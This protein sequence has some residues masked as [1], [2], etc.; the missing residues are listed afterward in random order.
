MPAF[1]APLLAGVAALQTPAAPLVL[2]A[3]IAL[4]GV[5][6]RI[7]HLALDEAH[8]R[9]FVA[10][11]GNGTLEVVDLAAKQVWKRVEGLREPQG[12]VYLPARGEVWV[13]QGAGGVL[14]VY[15]GET[16]ELLERIKLGPDGDNLSF[17]PDAQQVWLG[18]ASGALACID[19]AGRK[20]LGRARLPGHPEA[21]ALEPKGKRVFANVPSERGVCVVDREKQEQ[22]AFWPIES[23]QANYPLLLVEGEKQLF[24]GCRNPGRLVALD[25][26]SGK[27]VV[28]LEL[29]GDADD[30][31]YDQARGRIY[32]SCGEGTIDV[33]ARQ[34]PA[35]TWK[36]MAVIET[37]KGARTSYFSAARKQ[38]FLA[39][40]KSAEHPAE[41]RVYAAQE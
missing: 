29:S 38:V 17:D 14:D 32:A 21:F 20:A 40:P 39:V 16:L 35:N 18:Y 11:L 5:E 7:D 12:A 31:W 36:R 1:L 33:F 9:L 15:K 4:P 19:A 6:G 24:V 41:I 30:L 8:A 13:S 26:D 25:T 23:A 37:A 3:S 2:V 22:V 27:E 10:A 28:A 34:L